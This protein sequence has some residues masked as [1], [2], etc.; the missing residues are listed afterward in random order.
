MGSIAS[1][2]EGFTPSGRWQNMAFALA[3]MIL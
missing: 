1:L 3:G 2:A